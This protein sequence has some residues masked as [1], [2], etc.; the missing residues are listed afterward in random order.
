MMILCIKYFSLILCRY[1]LATEQGVW[2]AAKIRR[3]AKA[4]RKTAATTNSNCRTARKTA[5]HMGE[6]HDGSTSGDQNNNIQEV[7]W[8]N[9]WY[10]RTD[11]ETGW[12]I[13]L[14]KIYIKK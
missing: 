9:F 10:R 5:C 8:I 2:F 6:I 1:R 4:L 7:R 11:S 12:N 14:K 3:A 13:N